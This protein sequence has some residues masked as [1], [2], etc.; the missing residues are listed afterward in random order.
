MKGIAV[1][2]KIITSFS[3][4]CLTLGIMSNP[5]LTKAAETGRYVEK[6]NIS[7]YVAGE[8]LAEGLF[9]NESV[10]LTKKIL[11]YDEK[12][13]T[14][15]V[16]LEAEGKQR[17]PKGT[18][19]Q[20]HVVMILNTAEDSSSD[21]VEAGITTSKKVAKEVGKQL[22]DF[23]V[24]EEKLKVTVLTAG[25]EA[26]NIGTWALTQNNYS[27]FESKINELSGEKGQFT[28]AAMKEAAKI[29]KEV[30]AEN[31]Y[32]LMVTDGSPTYAYSGTYEFNL[33][34]KWDKN[35]P[36]K[37]TFNDL[38]SPIKKEISLPVLDG[39]Y[40]I[41]DATLGFIYEKH[42]QDFFGF[43]LVSV[44]E[45]PEG[46]K[47]FFPGHDRKQV[48]NL[49]LPVTATVV[50]MASAVHE[51]KGL[52]EGT[53]IVYSGV[54][55]S[56]YLQN[57][58]K[59]YFSQFYKRLK[60]TNFDASLLETKAETIFDSI[61]NAKIEDKL[62]DKFELVGAIQVIDSETKG[63]K[64]NKV[65]IT[66][67]NNVISV[68]GDKLSLGKD[69]KLVLT[70]K[71]RLKDS[72]RNDTFH[73]ISE[74][75]NLIDG[76]VS[77]PFFNVKAK[78]KAAP[79]PPVVNIPD[80]VLPPSVINPPSTTTTTEVTNPTNS[81]NTSNTNTEERIPK[82]EENIVVEEDSTPL[83]S[84]TDLSKKL[85]ATDTTKK[86][87]NIVVNRVS[88]NLAKVKQAD[89]E[90]ILSG[91][92]DKLILKLK[93][94]TVEIKTSSL[95][96]ILDDKKDKF[97]VLVDA[98]QPKKKADKKNIK[99]NLKTNV[100]LSKNVYNL[101]L[102]VNGEK[103]TKYSFGKT[104]LKV[105]LKVNLK[106]VPKNLYVMNL[107][108]KKLIKAKYDKKNRAA[109]FKTSQIGKFIVVKKK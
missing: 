103:I 90:T 73:E 30:E 10:K 82:K 57:I 47:K 27:E 50:S 77:Y 69:D 3:V 6:G 42:S 94:A 85:T 108:T 101:T 37:L 98:K 53:E 22:A 92:A 96:G 34:K 20:F 72:F 8:N 81:T 48:G 31:K 55:E 80:V 60:A 66:R 68:S 44:K 78:E 26:K 70:Y 107:S 91:E 64:N 14:F 46:S 67:D 58:E 49:N 84:A 9:E 52:P 89:V 19:A 11:S 63:I 35:D 104:P 65:T 7:N 41:T 71:V 40:Q 75:T 2:G 109:V 105:F 93:K 1:F 29:L 24:D 38:A 16:K 33:T 61:T 59:K 13:K 32:L 54:E 4:A 87:N 74:V 83:G 62:S 39:S 86:T 23:N 28:A 21:E 76:D 25:A 51:A 5:S 12:E 100:L 79:V 15:T 106:K 95:S 56:N 102:R 36:S 99:L 88:K 97:E 17:A 43:N 18:Q 45:I